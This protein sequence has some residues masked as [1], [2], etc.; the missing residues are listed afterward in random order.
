MAERTR[1]VRR[2]LRLEYLTL[3]WNVVGVIVL[4]IAAL[5]ARSIALAGFGFD[6]LVEIGAS[7]VVVWELT[8]VHREREQRAMRLIGGAFVLLIAY[9]VALTGFALY[10]HIHP[11]HSPPGI[12]WTGATALAMFALASGKLRT[13]R[14]L[15]SPVLVT[16][17]RVTLIDGYL[18][19]SVLVGLS[20]NALLGWWWA[21]PLAGLVVVYYSVQEARH[22]FAHARAMPVIGGS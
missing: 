19:T 9:L 13:G 7:T 10:R 6:T 18:A 11:Q 12:A 20:L 21:D 2:G 22:A 8:G 5:R 17:G 15:D 4:V 3:S 14:A 1:L 16:E